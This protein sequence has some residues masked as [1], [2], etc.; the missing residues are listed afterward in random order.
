MIPLCGRRKAS[1]RLLCATVAIAGLAGWAALASATTTE[2]I[3]TDRL[4]G[5]AIGGFDPVAYF[6]DHEPVPGHPDFELS[7]GGVVWRFANEGNRA[8][9]AAD[10]NVYTP[11]F[12][13]YDPIAVARGASAAGH[14]EIWL[15][16]GS[17]LYLFYSAEARDTFAADPDAARVAAEEN[18][19]RVLRTLVP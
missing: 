7:E 9:F 10:P 1:L 16:S 14:P 4:T 8:A 2:R 3:V 5:I 11:Q 15:I 19:P 13:G 18:W 6:T 17:R 12:G